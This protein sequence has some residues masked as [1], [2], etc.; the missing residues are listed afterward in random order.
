MRIPCKQYRFLFN[1]RITGLL[2]SL[3]LTLLFGVVVPAHH[4]DDGTEHS[5]CVLCI[6]AVQPIVTSTIV[7]LVLLVFALV[8]TFLPR[9]EPVSSPFIRVFDSRAPPQ[10]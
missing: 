6:I 10:I 2:L 5:D 9:S 1:H 3:Y 8:S 4:H 7:S